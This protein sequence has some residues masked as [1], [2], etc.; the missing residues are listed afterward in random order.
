MTIARN[1][2]INFLTRPK[3]RPLGEGGS[4]AAIALDQQAAPDDASQAF[5]LEYRRETFRWAARQVQ[6]T[7]AENTWRA[8][9]L[10]TMEDMPAAAA[11]E[12]LDMTTGGVY[13]A[14]SRV[15]AR[16]RELARQ[17]EESES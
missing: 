12:Q 16:L 5:D 15:M 17:F 8:F 10:T 6:E 9:W 1:T 2:A 11:A 4:D 13:I 7:V 14:R 3:H